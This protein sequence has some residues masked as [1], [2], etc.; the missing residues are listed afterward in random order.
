MKQFQFN[1]DRKCT[2]WVREDHYIEAQSY[3]QAREIMLKNFRE[4]NTD[5]SF[6]C[7]E[8]QLETLEDMSVNENGGWPTAELLNYEG[9]SIADNTINK[10]T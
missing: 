1:I 2:M 8:T 10:T 5:K 3:E 4:N 6:I 9:D 7:Q